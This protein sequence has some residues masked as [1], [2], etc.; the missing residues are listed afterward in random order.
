MVA[1]FFYTNQTSL[2]GGGT[3][4]WQSPNTAT[5]PTQIKNNL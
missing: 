2:R 4:T 3:T 1:V 5:S